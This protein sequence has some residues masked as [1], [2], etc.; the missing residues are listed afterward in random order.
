VF[1]KPFL[2]L[3]L[4]YIWAFSVQANVVHDQL[5]NILTTELSKLTGHQIKIENVEGNLLKRVVLQNVTLFNANEPSL[6]ALASVK[7]LVIEFNL[8]KAIVSGG[9]FAASI[10]KITVTSPQ[11]YLQRGANKNWNFDFSNLTPAEGGKPPVL[12]FELL[13]TDGQFD[14][15]DAYHAT[16]FKL[17]KPFEQTLKNISGKIFFRPSGEFTADLSGQWIQD[18]VINPLVF[19]GSANLDFSK[20][21]LELKTLRQVALAPLLNYVLPPQEINF[22]DLMADISLKLAAQNN[23][24]L[25]TQLT[26]QLS[27]GSL[28][29]PQAFSIPIK[30]IKG[31]ISLRKNILNMQKLWSQWQLF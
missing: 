3:F 11:I 18:K 28:S 24:K 27:Q 16:G 22:S 4:L 23:Q 15:Q 17:G 8:A 12:N 9:D 14:I 25:E 2:V 20:S 21:N 6:K 19:T 5:K 7:E 30:N 1:K 13:V 26:M 29:L 10:K 31:Q